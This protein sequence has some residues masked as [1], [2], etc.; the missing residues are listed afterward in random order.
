MSRC[1]YCFTPYAFPLSWESLFNLHTDNGLCEECSEKLEEIN[2]DICEMCGRPFSLFPEQ[3]R[4]ENTCND[5][6]RWESDIVWTG[7]L[8]GNRSLYVYNPFMQE[9]LSKYKYRGDA[10]LAKV[11]YNTARKMYKKEFQKHILVPI[12]LSE[13]RHLERG[14][15]QSLLI[16]EGM[17]PVHNVLIRT[18]H[19][20][21]Q[22]KK[23]RA[24]R[25]NMENKPFEAVEDVSGKKVLLIDDVYTTGST[26]RQAAKTLRDA[27]ASSVSSLTLAR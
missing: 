1:L 15:N 6:V 17:G 9:M 3:Y 4:Q 21:K 18:S 22:S 20:Q 26:I 23:N 16:A 24:E 12:P 14:F 19:E 25:M 8:A 11:F 13:E 10:E 5:C 7:I 2:G 27:G